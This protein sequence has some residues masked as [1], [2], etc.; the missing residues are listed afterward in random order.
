M[1]DCNGC[2]GWCCVVPLLWVTKQEIQTIADYLEAPL[3]Q[4]AKIFI[5]HPVIQTKFYEVH[6]PCYFWQ[7]GLCC[8]YPVRP[9]ACVEYGKEDNCQERCKE[10]FNVF[11][12]INL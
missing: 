1:V 2:F 11:G 12:I 8:V 10:R 7:T 3:W 6:R 4:I 5:H 9:S